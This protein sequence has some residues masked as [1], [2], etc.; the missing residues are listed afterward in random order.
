VG[1]ILSNEDSKSAIEALKAQKAVAS[2]KIS[3][4]PLD[5]PA[6]PKL[7]AAPGLLAT[8]ALDRTK[9]SRSPNANP[10]AQDVRDLVNNLKIVQ[11]T[12]ENKTESH[13]TKARLAIRIADLARAGVITARFDPE[14]HAIALTFTPANGS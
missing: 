11:E 10:S 6:P 12:L 8:T 2:L 7:L 1:S 9:A 5:L 14:T 4:S 13:N 3:V